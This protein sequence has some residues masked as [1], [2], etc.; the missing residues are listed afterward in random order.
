KCVTSCRF[1]RYPGSFRLSYP[2]LFRSLLVQQTHSAASS[3]FAL[4]K[5]RELTPASLKTPRTPRGRKRSRAA[6]PS[7]TPSLCVFASWRETKAFQFNEPVPLPPLFLGVRRRPTVRST[8]TS[9]C[10]FAPRD[11]G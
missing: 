11:R 7:T 10:R 1:L 2:T 6:V 3:L 5:Q 4:P 8:P 9:L